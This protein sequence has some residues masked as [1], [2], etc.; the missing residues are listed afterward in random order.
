MCNKIQ[1]YFYLQKYPNWENKE[2]IH[3]VR[4][5][6]Q[7]PLIHF[8]LGWTITKLIHVQIYFQA[9]P[10]KALQLT[11]TYQCCIQAPVLTKYVRMSRTA[12]DEPRTV[13]TQG[14]NYAMIDTRILDQLGRLDVAD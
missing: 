6:T 1:V 10:V 2:N 12:A 13:E 11:S 5:T 7:T 9:H 8:Q 3:P 4:P 14:G